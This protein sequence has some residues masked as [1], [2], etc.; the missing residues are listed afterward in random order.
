M[1]CRNL[2]KQTTIPSPEHRNRKRYM[3][4]S[5][6]ALRFLCDIWLYE[7]Y[8][9][10]LQRNGTYEHKERFWEMDWKLLCSPLWSLKEKQMNSKEISARLSAAKKVSK[11]L[12]TA[13]CGSNLYPNI[14]HRHTVNNKFY[15]RKPTLQINMTLFHHV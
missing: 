5:E 11:E 10:W 7:I 15:L 3:N 1:C 4:R 13:S 9:H 2:N 12:V 8:D 6:Y 14:H